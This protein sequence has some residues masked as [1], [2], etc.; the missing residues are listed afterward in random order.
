MV[1]QN[2]QINNIQN[3]HWFKY[4]FTFWDGEALF[5]DMFIWFLVKQGIQMSN[6]NYLRFVV[7]YR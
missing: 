7:E 3:Y 2:I 4:G 6:Q 1:R 5:G